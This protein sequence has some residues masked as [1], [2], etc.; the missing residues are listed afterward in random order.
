MIEPYVSVQLRSSYGRDLIYPMNATARLFTQLVGRK[1]F[2]E[3]DLKVISNLG[4]E[5]RWIS[6]ELPTSEDL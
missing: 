6:R 3:A 5:I 2:H 4:Y 1:T